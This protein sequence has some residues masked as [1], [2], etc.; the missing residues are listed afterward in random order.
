MAKQ[1]APTVRGRSLTILITCVLATTMLAVAGCGGSGDT[2]TVTETI[3]EEATSG[4]SAPTDSARSAPTNGPAK[5]GGIEVAVTRAYAKPTVNYEGG[6]LDSRVTPNGEPRTIR[7]PQG[8]SYVYVEATVVNESPAGIDLTCSYPME[9]KLIE[10]AG[11]RRFDPVEG[12]DL[13]KGNP[14]CNAQLQPGFKDSMTW[15]F[16]IPPGANVDALRFRDTTNLSKEQPPAEI[17]VSG[18]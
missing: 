5:S 7:A 8:G 12:L 11:G 4:N 16:L 17:A 14:E 15:I 6:T 9:V 1:G 3:A 18:I 10:G 13:V 2:Q